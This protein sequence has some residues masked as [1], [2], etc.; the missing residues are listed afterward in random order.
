MN[1]LIV[2]DTSINR[3]ICSR[4]LDSLGYRNEVAEGGR[5]VVELM[6]ERYHDFDIIFTDCQMPGMDG[7]E[8]TRVIRR[9]EQEN[10]LPAKPIIALTANAHRSDR[11]LCFEAGM[12]DFLSKPFRKPEIDSC[13]KKWSS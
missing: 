10:K 2:D 12:S 8:M 5:E 11:D 6:K 3:V 13:I 7:Y 4:L 1:I 9:Y